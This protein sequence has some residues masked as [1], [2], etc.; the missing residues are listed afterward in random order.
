MYMLVYFLYGDILPYKVRS[1]IQEASPAL[2]G[3]GVQAR[4]GGSQ[5]WGEPWSGDHRGNRRAAAA[6]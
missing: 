6:G 3:G 1:C 2:R 5:G 4:E